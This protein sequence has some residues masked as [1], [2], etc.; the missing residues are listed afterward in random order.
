FGCEMN[1]PAKL[2]LDIDLLNNGWWHG[3]D[4]YRLVIDPF[5]NRFD[6]IRVM[7]ASPAVRSYRDTLGRGGY[8]MW[9]DEP[10]YINR[11]GKI[12]VESSLELKTEIGEDSYRIKIK[13]PYNERIPFKPVAGH[14]IGWRIYFTSPDPDVSNAWATVY[15]QYQ[16]FDVTLK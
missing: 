1:A 4:N 2:H 16:F 10:Q 7:D 12:L 13:I 11:F 3:K 8:E 14:Q 6:E 15:E 5:S 9:D